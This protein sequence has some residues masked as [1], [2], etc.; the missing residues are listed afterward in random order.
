MVN[1]ER[2]TLSYSM[3]FLDEFFPSL[4]AYGVRYCVLHGWEHLPF[5]IGA[6]LNIGLDPDDFQRFGAVISH[7]AVEGY[8]P[9]Y[10]VSRAPGAWSITFCWV[11][12]GALHSVTVELVAELWARQTRICD[13]KQLVEDRRRE[14]DFWIP[15]PLVEFRIL[16]AKQVRPH[17]EKWHG[18]RL[19]QLALTLGIDSALRII[20]RIFKPGF[21]VGA[22][23]S[24]L[25]AD[26]GGFLSV[27][28]RRG[29]K[30]PAWS[31]ALYEIRDA[32]RLL[33]R[34]EIPAGV[35]LVVS[36]ANDQALNAAR[37]LLPLLA[38]AFGS[39]RL[40]AATSPIGF[41]R[42]RM[43]ARCCSG[44]TVV[45][46]S[47]QHRLF[48]LPAHAIELEVRTMRFGDSELLLGAV[49]SRLYSR[50]CALHPCWIASLPRPVEL[51]PYALLN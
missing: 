48:P 46:G 28:L 10:T 39:M 8:V 36:G 9:V 3:P 13:G 45:A 42:A 40:F 12:A 44:L 25:A 4:D 1:N 34:A 32:F 15:S 38:P 51:K 20:E 19:R 6:D 26:A 29:L 24:C 23:T 27:A 43:H 35:L 21:I 49:L 11:D 5:A 22:L 31:P 33:A 18:R 2:E 30:R 7:L 41:M 17:T 16:L 47:P 14:R 50:F 37:W